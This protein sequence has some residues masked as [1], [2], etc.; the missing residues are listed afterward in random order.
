MARIAKNKKKNEKVVDLTPDKEKIDKFLEENQE[1]LNSVV[2][3]YEQIAFTTNQVGD[4]L[5]GC[6]ATDVTPEEH[7]KW[8]ATKYYTDI[9][10]LLDQ[11]GVIKT[12][13]KEEK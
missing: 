5:R 2:K 13:K 8:I 3:R 7:S 12:I 1:D 4:W 11:L 9:C 10:F 6:A